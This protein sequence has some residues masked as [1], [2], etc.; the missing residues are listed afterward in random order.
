MRYARVPTETM[1]RSDDEEDFFEIDGNIVVRQVTRVG[2]RYYCSIDEWAPE[3]G[4]LLTD[5][6]I[7]EDEFG[8]ESAITLEEFERA[9]RRGMEQRQAP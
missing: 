2:D 1:S 6:S 5:Q 4:P 9:W 7:D 8:P 3:I